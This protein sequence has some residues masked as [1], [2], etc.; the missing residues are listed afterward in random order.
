[1]LHNAVYTVGDML[2]AGKCRKYIFCNFKMI[3]HD[4]YVYFILLLT[5][6]DNIVCP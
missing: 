3:S 2:K 6:S 5:V 1:M 4:L